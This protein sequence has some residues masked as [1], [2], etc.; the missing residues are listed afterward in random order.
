VEPILIDQGGGYMIRNLPLPGI[1]LN[2]DV[3]GSSAGGHPRHEDLADALESVL[4][5]AIATAPVPDAW[6]RSRRGDGEVSVAPASVP[7]AWLL[8]DFLST[9]HAS[10]KAY[11]RNKRTEDRLRLR[12]G[13]DCGDVL[14]NGR[15]EPSGGDPL[16]R[17]ARL[18]ESLAAREAA[19]AVPDAPLVAV[20]S[21][22]LYERVVPYQEKGLWPREF[23]E[24]TVEIGDA[25]VRAWLYVP[26]FPPPR[27]GSTPKRSRPP[28]S[29]APP[30][31]GPASPKF[32]TKV[33]RSK[34]VA[35]GDGTVINFGKSS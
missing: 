25:P 31:E 14:I 13:V 1:V 9:V 34:G 8:A 5:E 32:R 18:Q 27:V 3:V 4:S 24:V 15:G 29:K 2:A 10:A 6:A 21:N 26:H 11:N 33:T 23:G 35:I 30:G 20:I 16:V 12:L 28:E 19:V 7:A 22:E 17:A